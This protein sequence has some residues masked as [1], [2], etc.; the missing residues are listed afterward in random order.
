MQWTQ[1]GIVQGIRVGSGGCV[2][3]RK[4]SHGFFPTDTEF[5]EG[6]AL[7]TR[8]LNAVR[9][10]DTGLYNKATRLRG[11]M[12]NPPAPR[13]Y[14]QGWP[15]SRGWVWRV[16]KAPGSHRPP[17]PSLWGR[18]H[19]RRCPVFWRVT[20]LRPREGVICHHG[21]FLDDAKQATHTHDMCE[22]GITFTGTTLGISGWR[23]YGPHNQFLT[24]LWLSE[25][26][27]PP[28]LPGFPFPSPLNFVGKQSPWICYLGLSWNKHSHYSN[29][30]QSST[31]VLIRMENDPAELLSTQGSTEWIIKPMLGACPV[32]APRPRSSRC[33]P[34]RWQSSH[35]RFTG[36]G[37]V[38]QSSWGTSLTSHRQQRGHIQ[39]SPHLVLLLRFIS[40]AQGNF[41]R[42]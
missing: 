1:A 4:G 39:L 30:M 38:E 26:G 7:Q 13:H 14:H 22:Q 32:P 3:R 21:H 12:F 18:R 5:T 40:Q 9:G 10:P 20:S 2:C 29:L 17:W 11:D 31:K 34:W 15:F 37:A 25:E 24:L 16:G 35:A 8:Q 27:L 28:T 19:V 33:L 42:D 23:D 41:T 6:T 36:K